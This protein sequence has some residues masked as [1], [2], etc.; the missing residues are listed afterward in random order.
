MDNVPVKE[1]IIHEDSHNISQ[2]SGPEKYEKS[3]PTPVSQIGFRDPASIGGGQQLTLIS[4]EVGVD[5]LQQV[6]FTYLRLTDDF[7]WFTSVHTYLHTK[8]KKKSCSERGWEGRD[9]K[10]KKL[11]KGMEGGIEGKGREGK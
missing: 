1:K 10:T 6:Y 2:I 8:G 7:T 9:R 5:V 4:M 3:N 11:E